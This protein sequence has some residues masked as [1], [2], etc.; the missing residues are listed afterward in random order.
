[1]NTRKECHQPIVMKNQ[2]K[3]KYSN[4]Y[5]DNY[6]DFGFT[7]TEINGEETLLCVLSLEVLAPECMLPY[8]LKS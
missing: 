2:K 6:M 4:K 7:S 8:K 1:M 5:D 3:R